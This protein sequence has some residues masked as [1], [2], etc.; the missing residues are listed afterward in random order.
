MT[1]EEKEAKVREMKNEFLLECYVHTC[2]NF[3]PINDDI[4]ENYEVLK[5]EVLRR[6]GGNK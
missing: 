2:V 1:R 4:I 5:S 6:M 3:N